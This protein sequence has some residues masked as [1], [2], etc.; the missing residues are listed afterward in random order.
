[1]LVDAG[2]LGENDLRDTVFDVC[3]CG[4]GPAGITL[5]RALAG[6]N[7][8]VALMEGGGLESSEES[9]SLYHG[10]SVG[11]PYPVDSSRLRYFGGTSNHWVGE[12]RE[13]DHR[14]FEALPHHPLNEWPI[15]ASDLDGYAQL[16]ADIL[17]LAPAV[18]PTDIFKGREDTLKSISRRMSAP[19]VFGL[20]YRDELARSGLIWLC[21]NANLVDIALEE[22]LKLVSHFAF[23]SHARA[24][25]FKVRARRYVVCCGA[26][27]NAR[28]LLN[29][30]RQMPQGVGNQRD[31]VG[32]FFSEHIDVTL[33]RAVLAKELPSHSEYIP[34]DTLMRSR[35]CLSYVVRLSPIRAAEWQGGRCETFP[36]RV[37]RAVRTDGAACI[38]AEVEGAVQQS[39]NRD[40]RVT[41][42]TSK[43]RFGLRRL[44]LDWT[45]SD[46]DRHTIR[47]A[48]LET[49]RALARHDLGRM[50]LASYLHAD[51]DTIS[52][53]CVGQSHHMCTTRMSDSPATGV[54]DRNC[55]VHDVGN[56]YV[57]GSSVFASAG[58]SNPTYTI[59][60]LALRLGSHLNAELG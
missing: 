22:N 28:I 59:V 46:L 49:G 48:A 2:Q 53:Y 14:D 33:G 5:A 13:L 47:T 18:Q 58:V 32:R 10:E 8:R 60:K 30:N 44:S 4:A 41:L 45:L 12:T 20:K 43:D 56:L 34:S 54:V 42:A 21:L 37:D 17:D 19:T 40:S 25:V 23:R 51:L 1:V 7:R 31:L 55:R 50:Q 24:H 15:G 35:R 6:K 39:A 9:Q 16:A 57:G 38:N 11:V 36:E 27:E 29:A 3:I 26:L 52:D